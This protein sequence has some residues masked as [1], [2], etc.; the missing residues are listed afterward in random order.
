[1]GQIENALMDLLIYLTNG[2]LVTGY[3]LAERAAQL[4]ALAVAIMIAATVDRLVQYQSVYAPQRYGS[5]AVKPSRV[6]RTA[7]A[8]TG[9]AFTLWIAATWSFQSLV[10]VIGAAMWAGSFVGLLIMPQQRWSLLWT[11]KAYLILYS[12]AVI[13]FRIYLGQTTQLP[14]EQLA[15][16]LGESATASRILAQNA[17]AVASVG[18]WVLWVIMPAG[19]FGLLLQNW[20]AQPMAL[21]GPVQGAQEVLTILRTRG[22]QDGIAI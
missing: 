22:N 6:P 11:T 17:G 9:V 21:I 18:T 16:V 8:M 1:M 3:F 4:V 5:G 14:P 2:V 7:Q 13:G 10:P 12:L 20:L 15:Q 19:F